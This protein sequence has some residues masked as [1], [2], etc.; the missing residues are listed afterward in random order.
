M[1][2]IVYIYIYIYIYIANLHV[3]IQYPFINFNFTAVTNTIPHIFDMLLW[4]LH[5]LLCLKVV[6]INV[7]YILCIGHVP[8]VVPEMAK[9]CGGLAVNCDG[10][11]IQYS[12]VSI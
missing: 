10:N 6:C 11:T 1:E 9:Q 2:I 7:L 12:C 3:N 4:Y 8:D 5:K